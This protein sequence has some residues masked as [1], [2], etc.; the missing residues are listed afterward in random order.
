MKRGGYGSYRGRSPLHTFLKVLVI[1][2]AAALALALIALVF[3]QRYVFYSVDGVQLEP[4]FVQ[5]GPAATDAAAQTPE[6][7]ITA[8]PSASPEVSAA[9]SPDAQS[10][11]RAVTLPPEALSDGTALRRT[12]EAGGNA[13]IFDMKADSGAL[14]YVSQLPLAIS[15][16][17]SSGDPAVNDAI[18]ALNDGGL[19][20]IA[21]VSCFKDN[22]L[23]NA[24]R[25]LAVTT[26]SGYRWTD[27]D[28]VRWVSPTSETVRQYVT[29]VCVELAKLGFREILLVNSGYPTEG[30]LSYIKK[31]SAYDKTRFGEV[32]D[33]FYA[34]VAA[35]LSG[36]DVKLSILTDEAT[37]AAGA[38]A[39]SGQSV[40]G[41]AA[42][43]D[44]VWL[45]G[46]TAADAQI[47]ADAGLTGGTSDVVYTADAPG[48]DTA[49]WAALT[50]PSRP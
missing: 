29:D 10:P 19:Y 16:K 50:I 35:A 46:G 17:V 31:G 25:S 41:L 49:S 27:P 11:L 15:A 21:R 5:S 20:T 1:V 47:L 45:Q 43:A 28:H 18:R 40:A 8:A 3:F 22:D 33:G 38:N 26:N 7:L 32:V 37:V 13:A 24:D 36:Y 14:A 44:R 6:P 12:E 4:P 2:L 34:Q 30:N 42:H 48:A 23:S 39:L 9:P